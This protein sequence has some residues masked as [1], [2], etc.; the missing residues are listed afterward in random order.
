MFE[1]LEALDPDSEVWLTLAAIVIAIASFFLL[2]R[3]GR[4]HREKQ[5]EVLVQQAVLAEVRAESDRLRQENNH[6][7]YDM[8][9][10]YQFV[11]NLATC[12][13]SEA[14]CQEFVGTV[15]QSIDPD[16]V[17]LFLLNPEDGTLQLAAHN[18]LTEL[19]VT[20]TGFRVGHGLVG[21]V[22]ANGREM[23]VDDA[24]VDPRF[25]ELRGPGFAPKF[26]AAIGLPLLTQNRVLGVTVVGR[27][28]GGF[29]QDELRL[30]FIIA[31]EGALYLQNQRLYEEVA[32]LAIVDG[33]TGLYNHRYFYEQLDLLLIEAKESSSPLSLLMIDIDNFKPFNDQ[34]GHLTGDAILREVAQLIFT[35]VGAGHLAARYGGEEFVVIMPRT[36][37]EAAFGYAERIRQHIKE[38]RFSTLD[39]R[40]ASVTVSIGLATY[41]DHLECTA[42]TLTD[43][44]AVADDQLVVY[45]KNG[46]RDRVCRPGDF[47]I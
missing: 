19:A 14:V 8:I 39:G 46:G 27:S 24:E 17:G 5:R 43:L 28:A 38:H 37:S 12:R 6:L 2:V 32:R 47:G 7:N 20:N 33:P 30:L 10:L 1:A 15:Q 41:P 18:G 21:W 44:I 3:A 40:E 13:S 22:A 34:F 11:N 9:V 29:S 26:R 4:G 42:N 23:L 25:P 36:D 45:A 16:V 35:N 31:N